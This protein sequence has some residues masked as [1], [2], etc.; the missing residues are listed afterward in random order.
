MTDESTEAALRDMS[1]SIGGLQSTVNNLVA[2]WQQQDQAASQGRRDLHQKFDVVARDVTGLTVKLDGA[3]KEIAEIKPSVRAFENAK[4]RA[5]GAQTVGKI[6]WATLLAA[7]A[8][9]G[10]VLANWISIG[11]KL[12]PHP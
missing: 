11:P 7:G 1:H 3:I 5:K 4:E 12:P 8:L 10:W 2:T 6:I 9:I